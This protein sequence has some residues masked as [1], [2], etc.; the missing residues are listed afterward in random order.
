MPTTTSVTPVPTPTLTTEIAQ[1]LLEALRAL[2]PTVPSSEVQRAAHQAAQ[3]LQEAL[4]LSSRTVRR[5]GLWSLAVL[6]GGALVGLI[7]LGL[8]LVLG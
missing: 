8:L 7:V 1:R 2:S 6:V 3:A 4:L 5:M